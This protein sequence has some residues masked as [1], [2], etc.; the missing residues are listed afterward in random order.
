MPQ[1]DPAA[2]L[3][4]VALVVAV[5]LGARGG[6]QRSTIGALK[7][8]NE[9]YES[10]ERKHQE[11]LKRVHREREAKDTQTDAALRRLGQRNEVLEE[12]VLRKAETTEI[13]DVLRQHDQE[14]TTRHA[15]TIRALRDLKTAQ[16]DRA[17]VEQRL[18]D[19]LLEATGKGEGS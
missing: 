1:L 18:L 7:E 8:Q 16:A 15:G 4:W 19:Q 3:T 14:A 12:L 10:R 13:V 6:I 9:A 5:I 17:G 2:V 11:E